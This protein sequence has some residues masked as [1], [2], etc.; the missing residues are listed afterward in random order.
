MSDRVV[1][2][3]QKACETVQCCGPI[4]RRNLENTFHTRRDN[5]S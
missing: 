3:I 1:S 5:E 2:D 4:W